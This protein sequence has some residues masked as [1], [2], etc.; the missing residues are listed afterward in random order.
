MG[1]SKR[2][3]AAV[4]CASFVVVACSS[5]PVEHTE[6]TGEAVSYQPAATIGHNP[7]PPFI[8]PACE[9]VYPS[10][11]CPQ[12][13]VVDAWAV[14]TANGQC[15]SITTKH[16]TWAQIFTMSPPAGYDKSFNGVPGIDNTR[17]VKLQSPSCSTVTSAPC[18]TYVYWPNGWPYDTDPAK[19]DPQALCTVE[20]RSITPIPWETCPVAALHGKDGGLECYCGNPEGD[21]CVTCAAWGTSVTAS[22]E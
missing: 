7:P 20:T 6:S 10:L 3:L 1:I 14:Q 15:P 17:N 21:K 9:V 11:E 18:C 2:W 13:Y 5:A 22:V 12:F 4:G 16:G 19:A 8:N